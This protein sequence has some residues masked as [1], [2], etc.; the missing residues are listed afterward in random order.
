MAIDGDGEWKKGE[1]EMGLVI[2]FFGW[3]KG[4]AERRRRCPK[5]V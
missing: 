4:G 2:D 1:E 3:G 5:K